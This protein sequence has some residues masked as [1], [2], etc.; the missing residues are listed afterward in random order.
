MMNESKREKAV[1]LY[2]E[3][4]SLRAVGEALGVSHE[5]VRWWLRGY[6]GLVAPRGGRMGSPALDKLSDDD[7]GKAYAR[8]GSL[9]KTARSLKCSTTYLLERLDRA[10]IAVSRPGFPASS[11]SLHA[12][13]VRYLESVGPP[14]RS[15]AEIIEGVKGDGTVKSRSMSS[16]FYRV[17]KMADSRI[18]KRG[19]LW[20]LRAWGSDE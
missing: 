6:E 4:K 12:R 7:L 11:S 15:I 18:V 16:A 20:G 3:L 1:D 2:R 19:K 10:G 5:T 13:A 8:E 14:F 17:L 9:R